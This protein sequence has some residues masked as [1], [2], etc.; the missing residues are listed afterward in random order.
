[1]L[2]RDTRQWLTGF[3]AVFSFSAFAPGGI[4]PPAVTGCQGGI[5]T[6]I[7]SRGFHS[8]CELL[9]DIPSSGNTVGDELPGSWGVN[10]PSSRSLSYTIM[11]PSAWDT[12]NKFGESGTQRMAVHGELHI[13]P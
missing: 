8:P 4:G 3:L 2:L 7:E 13:R 10:A 12:R 9:D 5:V 11:V 1:M 6:K